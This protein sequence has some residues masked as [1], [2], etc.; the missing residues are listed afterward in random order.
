MATGSNL[1]WY[2]VPTG[3]TGSSS[4]PT[5]STVSPGSTTYYVSQTVNTCEGPRAAITVTVSATTPP[6]TISSPVNYCQNAVAVPLT[7]VGTNLLWYTVPTGGTGSPTAPTP[8]T[9]VV[10][11]TTYYV[12]QTLSCGEGPRAAIT[13]VINALPTAPTVTSPVTYCQNVTAVPLTATGSNL[14]WYT[15]PTGGTGSSSAPTPST[16]FVGSTNYYV[17][18]TVNTC[19]GPRAS[20]T[21]VINA[22]PAAPTVS[23][24]VTYCQNATAVPLSATGSN[25]LW[26]TVPT[27]GTG[28]PT[29]P[30]PSTAIVGS[31]SYYV[32]QTV[33]TC[34]GPRA[35][36]AVVINAIPVAPT[37]SSPVN[38]CQNAPAVPLSATGSNLLWYTVP[39]GGTGSSTAPTPS[40]TVVGSTTYYV[41]QT[42]NT[43][44]GPRAAIT[45]IVNAVP[46]APTVSTPVTYCQNA[47]AVQLTATGSN[48]LWYTTP[49][50]GSGS[51]TAPTP[52]T[53]APGSTTYYV[54]QTVS[55]CE[56]PR[57]AITVIV[58]PLPAAPTVTSPVTYCQNTVAVPLTA[59]G[60]NL[61]WYTTPTGGTGSSTAPTPST[62]VVGSTN[63]YVSQTVNTCE[64]P[65]A[66]ITVVI[67]AIPVAPTVSSP[68]TYC[69]NAVAVP[70]TATGTNL[71]WYTTPTGGTGSAT[72]P[73]PST[74]VV[75]ST[76]YYVSQ[77]ANTCE[78]PRAVITVV[79]NAI[80]TAP[81]VSTPVTYCQNTVA[82]AL[83]AT[84]PNL[85]WYTTPTGG[86]GSTTAPT[87]STTVAG[88]TTYYVSQTVNT[89]EGPRA[90]I[91]VFVNAIPTAPA[92]T[93]PVTYCQNAV[94]VPLTATG[95]N[96]LWYAAATGG[97]GTTTAPTPSTAVVGTIAYYVSQTVNGCESPR[98]AINVTISAPAGPPAVTSPVT[99]C[100]NATATALT[101]TGTGLLWFTTPTGG[102]G[103]P[104]APV[105]STA[106]PG[107]FNFY[108]NQ[109]NGCGQ[110][111]R[112]LINVIVNPTPAAA[113]GLSV[114][115]ITTN[116]ALLSWTGVAGVYYSV[117]Y[118]AT[119]SS[120]WINLATGITS[121][122]FQLNNLTVGTAYDWRVSANCASFVLINYSVAQFT[123]TSHN[124]TITRIHDGMGIKISPNPFIN[125]GVI[126][127]IVPGDG[128]VDISLHD[129]IGQKLGTLFSE[130]QY[131]GR[132]S[133]NITNQFNGL[134][135]GVYFI[136]MQQLARV[137]YAKFEKQ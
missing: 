26:Y 50:G 75:G 125:T 132:Y 100:H 104:T 133:F 71:L 94:A 98:A 58:N 107:S 60:S 106:I 36:I 37:A 67:N 6:P 97:T 54:S 105:P 31:T 46:T 39:T 111:T 76:T 8:S 80:P 23:S 115:G 87:P 124:N 121:N 69:Q 41:S 3:G 18:Q 102:T 64:G 42:I 112:A 83:T 129:A 63:Y 90:A 55:T 110:G 57:A 137:Y 24:P 108:V 96:L 33:N 43:C 79:V 95:S 78:G 89:C 7:A 134:I 116:S 19:E 29:A 15:V 74:A 86:T 101:A 5:P 12:S 53:V 126:D 114:T 135:K 118:K 20:I 10:G 27:G 21:V 82:V 25:L 14:L 93:T 88:S 99:Y 66:S 127:Y 32:S 131:N 70:L 117:D 62:A 130:Y 81:A 47:T 77:T 4:A 65:R 35:T 72:A 22:L 59:T 30:T 119:S 49:T 44:E 122:S 48:L 123:T 73:T 2:T 40:T 128:R 92:V 1:L 61:L 113:T 34:E 136:K 84:G 56:S 91:T 68:V 45:V 9:A 11:S 17:S 28:S 52:T 103:N 109:S 16:A 85:L 51:S 38:Y 120:T 13:V